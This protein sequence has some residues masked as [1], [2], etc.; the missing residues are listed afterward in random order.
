MAS[1]FTILYHKRNF[2]LCVQHSGSLNAPY[3]QV[4]FLNQKRR[5]IAVCVFFLDWIACLDTHP[6]HCMT[7][8]I[9]KQ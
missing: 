6:G 9:D 8:I 3:E 4:N 5:F 7:I 1:C 2:D